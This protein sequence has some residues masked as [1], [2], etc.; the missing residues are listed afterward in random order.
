MEVLW[1][2]IDSSKKLNLNIH[3]GGTSL[4]IYRILRCGYR[5]GF[6]VTLPRFILINFKDS[7]ENMKCTY[8]THFRI[9]SGRL[10]L[11]FISFGSY[12][13]NRFILYILRISE[14]I[15]FYTKKNNK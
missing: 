5:E 15:R 3:D 9:V 7:K 8:D 12:I 6:S 11:D 14:Q 4:N 10:Y 2:P 13:I 1:K